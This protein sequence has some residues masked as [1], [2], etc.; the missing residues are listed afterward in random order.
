MTNRLLLDLSFTKL[1]DTEK[2]QQWKSTS[3]S[4]NVFKVKEIE[5]KYL[6]TVKMSKRLA[7]M[8]KAK[9]KK[10]KQARILKLLETRK[11]HQG[12]GY[13]KFC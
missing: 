9:L 6:P 13:T 3:C 5:S 11:C 1:S 4:D 12:H 7:L 10:K 2:R 8:K